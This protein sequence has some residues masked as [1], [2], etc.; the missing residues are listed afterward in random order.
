MMLLHKIVPAPL[1]SAALFALWLLLARSTSAGTLALALAF[2]IVVPIVTSKLR[3]RS[4]VRRPWVV[5]R[6]IVM[7]GYDV[8]ASSLEVA[9]GVLRWWR[10]PNS[11][12]VVIP[13][14]LRAPVALTAL[15]MVTTVVPGTVWSELAVDRSSLLLHVWDVTEEQAFVA[16]YKRR[17]EKPLQE[18]FE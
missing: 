16:R 3:P 6:F 4:R 12:F 7:V 9:W 18:I 8:I 14:E 1:L 13:L 17:Y 11:R 10:T 5:V 2:A 15:S